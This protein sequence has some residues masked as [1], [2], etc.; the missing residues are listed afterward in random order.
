[1]AWLAAPWGR[2][3]ADRP[4]SASP[5]DLLKLIDVKQHTVSG[6]W[7]FEGT[8]LVAPAQ[9][10]VARLQVPFTPPEEYELE[11]TT[12]REAG[13]SAFVIGLVAGRE[14]LFQVALDVAG[15]SYLEANGKSGLTPGHPYL[16]NLLPLGKMVPIVCT[17]RKN[18]VA[19]TCDGVR[20]ILWSGDATT[21]LANPDWAVPAKNRL[22]LGGAGFHT[23][24]MVLRPLP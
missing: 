20:I 11:I 12:K 5:I 13:A 22:Y 15:Q 23:S 3:A 10:S 24:K 14:K 9:P 2:R 19:V 8:T 7:A 4:S 21:L 1:V 16:G 17:V 18:A 6:E